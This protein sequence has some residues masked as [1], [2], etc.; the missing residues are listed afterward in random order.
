MDMY[1][2]IYVCI[3]MYILEWIQLSIV[4]GEMQDYQ[5]V[6][7][8]IYIYIFEGE[9]SHLHLYIYMYM[10]VCIVICILEWCGE[11]LWMEE[12]KITYRYVYMYI[13]EYIWSRGKSYMDMYVYIHVYIYIC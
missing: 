8:H 5:Q 3:V 2:Y 7:I 12:G 13:C 11:V 9:L 6:Y 10:Y 4:N 1:I